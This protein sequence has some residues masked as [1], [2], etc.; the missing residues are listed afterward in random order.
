MNRI[1]SH[2]KT[3]HPVALVN[4]VSE[5]PFIPSPIFFPITHFGEASA[6]RLRFMK[7]QAIVTMGI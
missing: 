2:G 4:V 6:N 7:V 1:S 3:G 5:K